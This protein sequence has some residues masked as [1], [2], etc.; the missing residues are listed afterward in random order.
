MH[1]LEF[2]LKQIGPSGMVKLF[3]F[4]IVYVY[5]TNEKHDMYIQIYTNQS[6]RQLCNKIKIKTEKII[7]IKKKNPAHRHS[8]H[9]PPHGGGKMG[10]RSFLVCFQV[11]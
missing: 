1:F 3:Y 5:H 7:I 9:H 2:L 4:D 11:K 8:Y 6:R 10:W